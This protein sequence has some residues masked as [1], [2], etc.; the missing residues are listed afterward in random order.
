MRSDNHRRGRLDGSFSGFEETIRLH[1]TYRKE[2][3]L[4]AVRQ[5]VVEVREQCLAQG[6]VGTRAA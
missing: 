5:W 6:V 1:F 4:K 2:A 3:I